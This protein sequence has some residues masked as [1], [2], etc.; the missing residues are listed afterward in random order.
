[1]RIFLSA[2]EASGDAYAAALVEELRKVAERFVSTDYV[3]LQRLA[4]AWGRPSLGT[5]FDFEAQLVEDSLEAVELTLLLEDEFGFDI[6]DGELRNLDTVSNLLAF[7]R[8]RVEATVPVQTP[9]H[10]QFEGIGGARMSATIGDLLADSSTWGAISIIQSLKIAPRAYQGFLRAKKRLSSGPP[11]ILVAIDFGFFNIRLCRF[12]KKRGWKVLY[13]MPPGSWR[14]DKQGKDLTAITDAIVTPFPWSAEILKGIGANAYFFGHPIKQLVRSR[15]VVHQAS[16]DSRIAVLPGSRTHE[17]EATLPMIAALVEPNAGDWAGGFS[18][19]VNHERLSPAAEV[20]QS[21]LEFAIAPNLDLEDIESRWRKVAPDRH[22]IFTQGDVYG[23]LDRARAAIVC[24]GT[25]TIE[26]ALMGCPH[27]VVYRVTKSM[28]REAKLIHFKMP[29]F[30]SLPNIILDRRLVPEL[31]GTE[32]DPKSIRAALEP[33][34][35]AGPERE[36]QLRGFQEIDDMLGPED[37]ITK[38]AEM[39]GEWVRQGV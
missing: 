9:L 35:D 34:L 7:L 5:V 16:A 15:Q 12:A 21:T 24:S 29:K 22:D 19:G 8:T 3:I 18:K 1:M 31:V 36:A 39:I 6:P 38:T 37:A 25:A 27:V 14:R 2:G 30:I 13:W 17:L 20:I 26:A 4:K 11:G 28:E 32:I 10:L 23:V 33:L